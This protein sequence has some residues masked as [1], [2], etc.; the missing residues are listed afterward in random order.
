MECLSAKSEISD[1]F[2][3][4]R[5]FSFQEKKEA[6]LYEEEKTNE[7][8]GTILAFKNNLVIKTNRINFLL[9]EIEK[10]TWYDNLDNDCLMLINDLISSIKDLHSTLVRQYISLDN[11]RSKGIAK[12]EIKE[13]KLAIDDLKKTYQDLES[14][15]FFL[16]ELPAFKET[17]TLLTLI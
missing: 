14:V 5:D 2:Q 16:P 12:E 4:V 6:F 1:T 7:F 15:F 11:I 8:L 9:E 3:R 17:T 10:S 13:F